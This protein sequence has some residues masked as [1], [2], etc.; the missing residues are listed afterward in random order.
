MQRILIRLEIS[1]STSRID[2]VILE[3][4]EYIVQMHGI[5]TE[6]KVPRTQSAEGAGPL[7]DQSAHT[8]HMWRPQHKPKKNKQ[9]G[10]RINYFLIQVQRIDGLALPKHATCVHF[11][12]T[13][14]K[15]CY[16]Y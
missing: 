16:F 8:Q 10:V 2:Q 1:V 14:E 12:E 5:Q 7:N 15:Y 13:R 9:C 6:L 3:V 11:F 4:K